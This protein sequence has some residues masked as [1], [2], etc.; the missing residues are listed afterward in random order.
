MAVIP[1][2]EE[3]GNAALRVPQFNENV[4][5]G[6]FGDGIARTVKASRPT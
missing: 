3:F 5:R 2:G 4:P 6:A 1:R